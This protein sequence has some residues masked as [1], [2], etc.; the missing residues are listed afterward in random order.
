MKM[1]SRAGD[2]QEAWDENEGVMKKIKRI[3]KKDRRINWAIG[4][5]MATSTKTR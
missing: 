1:M 4:T 2:K 3:K 5:E